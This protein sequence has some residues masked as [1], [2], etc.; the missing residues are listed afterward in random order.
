MEKLDGSIKDYAVLIV[1]Y[2]AILFVTVIKS[3]GSHLYPRLRTI[4]SNGDGYSAH[5][6]LSLTL[7][8]IDRPN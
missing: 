6:A 8:H 1:W 2:Y 5:L 4:F 7:L 3:F